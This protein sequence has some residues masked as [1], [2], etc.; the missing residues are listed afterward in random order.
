M[1]AQLSVKN[2]STFQHFKDRNPPWVKL[3]KTIID[4]RDINVISDCAFRVLVFCWLLA[5]EDKEKS[6]KL[7]DIDT[8]AFRTRI[9]KSKIIKALQELKNFIVQDDINAISTRYQSDAPETET[10]TEGEAEAQFP[11]LAEAPDAKL[12]TFKQWTVEDLK[13]SV[14]ENNDDKLLTDEEVLDFVGYWTEKSATGRFRIAMEKTWDTR[15]RMQTAVRVIY[16]RQ[17]LP[18]GTRNQSGQSSFSQQKPASYFRGKEKVN[19]GF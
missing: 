7:P 13:Q 2:W 18:D 3:H 19:H 15:R 9:D 17:R 14:K 10:E 1:S 5:S 4:D 16:S 6:G 11:L 12:K 8:I